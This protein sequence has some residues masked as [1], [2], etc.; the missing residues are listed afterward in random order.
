MSNVEERKAS[1]DKRYVIFYLTL[2][3][4]QLLTHNLRI[5]FRCLLIVRGADM[6]VTHRAFKDLDDP[7]NWPLGRRGKLPPPAVMMTRNSE[8]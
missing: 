1:E 2:C 5:G 4:E 6:I 8:D 7:M 3:I